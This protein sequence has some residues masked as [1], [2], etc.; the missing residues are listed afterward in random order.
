MR[1]RR[2]TATRRRRRSPTGSTRSAASTRSRRP[3]RWP[4]WPTSG[5]ARAA[6][7]V[8]GTVPAVVEMQS[9]GGRG[10]RAARRAA[11]RGAGDDVHRLPGPAADDPE[12]VQDRRRADAGG[13]ARGRAVAR[14]AGAVDLRRPLRRDGG[15]PDR[16]RAAGVGVGAGGPRP[17]AGRAGGD[18]PD[19]G[20]VRALLRRVPHLARAEHDRAARRRRPARARPRGARPRAPRAGALAGAAVH[21]RHRAEPGRLLPGARDGQPVLRPRPGRRAGRDGRGSPSAPAAATG[22]STTAGTPRPSACS[23]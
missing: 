12:H 13:A 23:W 10:G 22:S 1:A 15:A 19:A 4:S 14:G 21:P 20:A 8:W 16:L 5:R 3:R 2:S 6:P 7:N 18:A 9:E 17:G 11:G